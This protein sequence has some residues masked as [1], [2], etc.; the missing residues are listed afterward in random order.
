MPKT[1]F[2]LGKPLMN[3]AGTLGFAPDIRA[4]VPWTA[5]GAFITNPVSLRP[6]KPATRPEAIEYPGGFLLHTGLPN[7]GFHSV[8][9]RYAR[10]WADASVPVIVHLMAD[11]PEESQEMTRRL[12][13]RENVLAIELGFAPLLAD[14]IIL[15]AIDMC[16]GELP[17]IACLP[18]ADVLRLGAAV[19]RAGA[20]AVSF[21]PP[22]GSL[23]RAKGP[24]SGRLFGPA[25]LPSTLDVV[26][27]ATKI[28]LPCLG[29]CGV[30]SGS[31]CTAML[32]AGAI[33]VELDAALWL[34]RGEHESLVG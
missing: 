18:S 27:S 2:I 1:D 9:A 21:A 19:V 34:P 3:A 7:P 28:G 29:S 17:L 4:P 32:A 16:R 30:Y 23:A 11:R 14:D 22:R 31:D 12:E 8:L 6:R 33:G 15:S 26:R 24:V 10:R 20:A 25:L 13:G 5:L